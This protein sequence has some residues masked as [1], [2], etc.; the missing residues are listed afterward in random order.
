MKYGA[1][2]YS[3]ITGEILRFIPS[4]VP[5][6]SKLTASIAES[7][8]SEMADPFYI[9]PASDLVCQYYRNHVSS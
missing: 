8:K 7:I 6:T 4:D 9:S 3:K 2:V 5:V 1:I